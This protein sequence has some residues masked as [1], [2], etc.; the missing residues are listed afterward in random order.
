MLP[1][2]TEGRMTHYVLAA[3]DL[4][5]HRQ[6]EI[7]RH[8][9]ALIVN[10]WPDLNRDDGYSNLLVFMDGINDIDKVEILLDDGPITVRS[11]TIPQF[12][13]RATSR[14]YSEGKE[15]GTWHWPEQA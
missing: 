11:C 14:V 7:G 4:P 5:A 9:P 2:C 10:S 8:R 15:P 6:H 13:Y 3:Q 12:I 1:G